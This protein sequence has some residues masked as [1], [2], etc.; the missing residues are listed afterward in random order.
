MSL[1]MNRIVR[2]VLLLGAVTYLSACGGSPEVASPL[3]VVLPSVDGGQVDLD[4]LGGQD[5]LL[6][7]WAPW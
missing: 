2:L 5:S 1:S 3:P 4:E 7:F 6:W